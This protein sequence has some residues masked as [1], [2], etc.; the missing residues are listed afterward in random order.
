MPLLI[1]YEIDGI[2]FSLACDFLKELGCVQYGKPDTHIKDIFIELGLLTGASKYSSKADYLALKIIDDL[3]AL[4]GVTSYAVDK[5]LWLV[6][7]GNYYLD[8]IKIGNHKKAFIA[9]MKENA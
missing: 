2:G 1:S 7:S 8:G 3:A 4:N 6:C 9:R 5:I